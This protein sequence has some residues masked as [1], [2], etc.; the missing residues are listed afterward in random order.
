MRENKMQS[1]SDLITKYSAPPD[2][3]ERDVPDYC[4]TAKISPD[5]RLKLEAIALHFDVKK[6]RLASEILESAI[7]DLFE[8]VSENFDEDCSRYYQD[9]CE[10]LENV[11]FNLR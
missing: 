7:N 4:F 5:A 1:L 9:E 6:T 10:E 8:E 3:Q 2:H 11:R